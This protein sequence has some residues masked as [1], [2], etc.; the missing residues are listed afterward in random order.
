MKLNTEILTN[1]VE[2]FCL[3]NQKFLSASWSTPYV[4]MPSRNLSAF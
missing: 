1:S 2:A 3:E 4:A